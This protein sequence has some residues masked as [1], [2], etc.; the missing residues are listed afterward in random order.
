MVLLLRLPPSPR[1]INHQDK[2]QIGT[3]LC[4]QLTNIEWIPMNNA[5]NPQIMATNGSN[6][7][8]SGLALMINVL[9]NNAADNIVPIKE[10]T[11]S[12]YKLSEFNTFANLNLKTV[13]VPK[14]R[15]DVIAI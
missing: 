3:R 15:K 10:Q 5:A 7:Q 9:A 2:E 4:F 1:D 11:P 14:R 12:L 8:I 13:N 6:H